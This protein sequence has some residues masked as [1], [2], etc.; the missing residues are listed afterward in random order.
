MDTKNTNPKDAIG[1]S[2]VSWSVIPPQVLDE[3]WQVAECK[4]RYSFEVIGEVGLALTEGACKY[5]A[6]N[7]RVAGVRASVYYNA[8]FRHLGAWCAGQDIDP[9]SG[10]SHI[11]K[12]IAGLVVIRDS[13]IVGNIVDD[14]PPR[15]EYLYPFCYDMGVPDDRLTADMIVKRA[16]LQLGEW[17]EGSEDVEG[18]LCLHPLISAICML[19]EVRHRLLEETIDLG[20]AIPIRNQN[21]VQR[22]NL[23]TKEMLERYP[24]PKQP[25]TERGV[26]ASTTETKV[27]PIDP[28]VE[29]AYNKTLA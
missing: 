28:P 11:V 3:I 24:E 21:W 17:W 1:I 10:L 22:L 29:G 13:M 8:A 20:R 6:Y 16:M 26:R 9:D 19:M 18:H 4:Y 23:A 7:W 15:V 14:R 12:A 5:G 27:I 25:Y 2:K